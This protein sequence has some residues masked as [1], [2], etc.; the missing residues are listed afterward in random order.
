MV[1]FHL[2]RE[3]LLRTRFAI[4]PLFELVSSV[5]LLRRDPATLA[6]HEPWA[7]AARERTAGSERPLLD[8]LVPA[9][10]YVPDFL[11]PPP[12]THRPDLEA[13]L[14][15]VERTP[16]D[17]LRR[18]VARRFADGPPPPAAV[19]ELLERPTPGLRRL[20]DEVR[21][22]W[23][24]AIA[25]WW[26]AIRG[27]CADD[28]A[29]RAVAST[30]DGPIEAFADL[31]EDV[32]WDGD[33]LAVAQAADADVALTG[34]GLLLVPSAFVWPKVV[35]V[36]DAPW[37]PALFY[38]PRGIGGL[39]APRTGEGRHALARLLGRRRAEVLL[40]LDRERSTSGLAAHIALSTS[41]TSEHLTTLREAGL[42]RAR[43]AGREVLHRR[44]AAGD[45]VVGGSRPGTSV[46]AQRPDPHPAADHG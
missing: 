21:G 5:M 12:A 8:A 38:P 30:V 16:V 20:A 33:V 34:R 14:R 45:A 42:V 29:H 11:S 43:R 36:H 17:R 2:T 32:G 26:E 4:S 13:E 25:P 23:A 3:D 31:H 39:W 44:T 46:D 18:E 22:H 37:P 6:L 19:V 28:I 1:R 41:S 7:R 10:G 24:A 15:R 40:A 35:A 9:T 27:A